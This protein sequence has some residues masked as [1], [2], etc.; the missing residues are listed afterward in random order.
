MTQETIPIVQSIPMQERQ[1]LELHSL[2]KDI[3]DY[4]WYATM[5]ELGQEDLPWRKLGSDH[6]IQASK[7]FVLKKPVKLKIEV[8]HIALLGSLVGLPISKSN[9]VYLERRLPG[10]HDMQIQGLNTGTIDLTLNGWGHKVGL[11]GERVPLFTEEGSQKAKWYHIP[12]AFLKEK[13][14]LFVLLEEAGGNRGKIQ[15]TTDKFETVAVELKPQARL[16]CPHDQ[17]YRLGKNTCKVPADPALF[18][19]VKEFCL[20]VPKTFAIH[21]SYAHARKKH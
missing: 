20:G 8:N 1:P 11:D 9:N 5:I 10:V 14:N 2:L 18:T 6:G 13:K 7:H 3:T 21:V 17:P 4:G 16:N 12:R 19:N 15:R